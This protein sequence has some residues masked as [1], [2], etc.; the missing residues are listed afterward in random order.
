MSDLQMTL[1]EFRLPLISM[2]FGL[3]GVTLRSQTRSRFTRLAEDRAGTF[4]FR[5]D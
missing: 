1:D 4:L 3:S 5:N 2:L